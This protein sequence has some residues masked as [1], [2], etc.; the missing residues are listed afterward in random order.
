[1]TPPKDIVLLIDGTRQGPE[2]PSTEPT[3]VEGLAYFLNAEPLRNS[4]KRPRPLAGK[5]G[6]RANNPSSVV[7]YLSG[8]GADTQ[9]ILDLFPAGTGAGTALTI[10]RAYR[11]LISNYE[12]ND[13]IFLF[14][15]S[16]GAFAAR[17]LAGFVDCIGVG[18]RTVPRDQLDRA[19]DEAYYA[20]E[21][22]DGDTK[23]LR[24]GIK[25]YLHEYLVGSKHDR[26]EREFNFESLPIYLIGIWDAVASLGL[27]SKA[28]AITR[29]FN[30]YHQTKLPPNV[31]HAFHVLSLHELRSDFEPHVWSNKDRSDQILEQRWF[32]GDHSDIG[33]GHLT[34]ELSDITLAW[35]L[36]RVGDA[37]LNVSPL[38]QSIGSQPIGPII[39]QSWQDH[40]YC[41]LCPTVRG[42]LKG[43]GEPSAVTVLGLSFDA[44]VIQRLSLGRD[45]DYS[46]YRIGFGKT[47]GI[48]SDQIQIDA[49]REVDRYTVR[50]L[51]R[52]S[53]MFNGLNNEIQASLLALTETANWPEADSVLR[54]QIGQQA[55]DEILRGMLEASTTPRLVLNVRNKDR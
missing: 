16:R 19:I 51:L 2:K 36:E 18:L 49:L 6:L 33:G 3:N 52:A 32:A 45:I 38:A 35:M 39:N 47:F 14:G 48:R 37:G 12:P 31:S 9:H 43:D 4:N 24:S 20:Y 17:S 30:S 10:R 42:I 13:R 21:Y 1:M 11:F 34:R 23:T 7:G 53:D 46:S 40:P 22:L 44:T 25:E 50:A 28:A 26:R 54:K 8:V 15:F 55:S 5:Q 29:V 27:P 41:L